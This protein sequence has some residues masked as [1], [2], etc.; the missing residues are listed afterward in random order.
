MISKYT[1]FSK[2]KLLMIEINLSSNGVHL[3]LRGKIS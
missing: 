3:T 2:K 1:L